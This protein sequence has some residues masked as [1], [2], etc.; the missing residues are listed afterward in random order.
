MLQHSPPSTPKQGL[1]YKCPQ[2]LTACLNKTT[3]EV[4]KYLGRECRPE[5]IIKADICRRTE[6]PADSKTDLLT[7]YRTAEYLWSD[8]KNLPGVKDLLQ[9][10]WD[11]IEQEDRSLY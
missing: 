2:P 1:R 10:E 7:E 3:V 8:F 5:I 4:F 6:E 11:I 9:G